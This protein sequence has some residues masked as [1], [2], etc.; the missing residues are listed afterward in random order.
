MEL[1]TAALT[2]PEITRDP[3]V[4][5]QLGATLTTTGADIAIA[6][7]LVQRWRSGDIRRYITFEQRAGALAPEATAPPVEL[8]PFLKMRWNPFHSLFVASPTAQTLLGPHAGNPD[9]LL[10]AAVSHNL[11]V[12]IVPEVVAEEP[13]RINWRRLSLTELIHK[14]EWFRSLALA[15]FLVASNVRQL[16]TEGRRYRAYREA[17]ANI[18]KQKEIILEF[19]I[20]GL[21]D[22]LC[23]TTLPRLLKETHGV[24]FYLSHNMKEVFRHPDIARLCFESNPFF[25]GYKDGPVFKPQNFVR[26]LSWYTF[27]TDRGGDTAVKTIGRQFGL[28]GTGSP[29]LFYQPKKLPGYETTLLCDT[30]WHSGEKWG[31]WNDP[32]HLETELAEWQKRGPAYQIEYLTPTG[33][34]IFAYLDKV[35]SSGHF[36]CYYSGGNALAAA[37]GKT[38]VTI[39]P[40]NLEGNALAL[41][42][43][44][45]SAI[46]YRRTKSLTSYY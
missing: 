45:D 35:Y 31:L 38:S 23:Y 5:E 40:E 8:G 17:I 24:D 18:I 28:P 33:Q 21:G 19:D 34:D 15:V 12:I 11:K 3:K 39:V 20:G 16:L 37:L 27:L 7:K 1:P 41:F 42:F 13:L 9:Q 14:V 36:V 44:K 2:R 46:T 10:K 30:N 43:F 29:E 4:I 25:K 26:E 6:G 32:V 22:S